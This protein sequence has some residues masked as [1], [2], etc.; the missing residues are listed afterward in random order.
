MKDDHKQKLYV[1]T[2]TSYKS[3]D[4]GH[5]KMTWRDTK[6]SRLKDKLPHEKKSQ[7]RTQKQ[8]RKE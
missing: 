5:E 2:P 7:G 1:N 6:R 3:W 8:P 4:E